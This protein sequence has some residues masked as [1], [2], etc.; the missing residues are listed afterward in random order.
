MSTRHGPKFTPGRNLITRK[1]L[2][3]RKERIEHYIP[4]DPFTLFVTDLTK[5]P[6]KRE[7]EINNPELLYGRITNGRTLIGELTHIG[8]ETLL[9]RIFNDAV[10]IESE[11]ID[12]SKTVEV[13]GKK[14]TIMGRVDA[15]LNNSI[16]VEIKETM[17]HGPLPFLPHLEQASIYNWLYDF[18][19]T[20]LLY[21][22]IEGIYEYEVYYRMPEDEII[23]RIREVDKAPLYDW[24]CSR[25][26]FRDICPFSK[27]RENLR[28]NNS[29]T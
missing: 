15:I 24:E 21:I 28:Q 20:I 3:Y 16:G 19:Y 7:H 11:G 4:R 29:T 23:R 14:Y 18:Q 1:L 12:I 25:C 2:E 9:K 10:K 17:S 13:D 22:S 26:E 8:V 5:C 6:M 27:L